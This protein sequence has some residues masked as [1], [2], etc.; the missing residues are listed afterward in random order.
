MLLFFARCNVTFHKFVHPN[1]KRAYEM[2]SL[3]SSTHLRSYH[4]F[5]VVH[6]AK[7]SIDSSTRDDLYES[8][9]SPSVG[10]KPL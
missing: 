9:S 3:M 7:K 2:D 5:V 4:I 6:A 8:V 1:Q 10:S